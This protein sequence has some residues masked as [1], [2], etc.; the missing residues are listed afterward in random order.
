MI[1][2]HVTVIFARRKSFRVLHGALKIRAANS[3][4]VIAIRKITFKEEYIL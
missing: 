1:G 3:A 2:Y 4:R